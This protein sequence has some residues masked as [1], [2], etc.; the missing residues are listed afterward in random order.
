MWELDGVE[1]LM[2]SCNWNLMSFGS[3]CD[4][5]CRVGKDLSIGNLAQEVWAGWGLRQ[6]KLIEWWESFE[7]N[8]HN[9]ETFLMR[10]PSKFP[11]KPNMMTIS[12]SR[13]HK[14]PLRLPL[15]LT[16]IQLNLVIHALS[17]KLV[18][19]DCWVYAPVRAQFSRQ[20]GDMLARWW[21]WHSSGSFHAFFFV[22]NVNEVFM[23][24]GCPHF[25]FELIFINGGE[26]AA[27]INWCHK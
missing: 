26:L 1:T 24:T 25:R 12:L 21:Y 19:S 22:S 4:L 2:R 23:L 10:K 27:L 11:C 17:A 14:F 15:N 6:E 5:R 3:E 8:F 13:A 9:L 20:V 7:W 18:T 16:R